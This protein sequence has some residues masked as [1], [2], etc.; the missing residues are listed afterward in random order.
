MG[1]TS[2][3]RSGQLNPT[4]AAQGLEIIERSTNVQAR[5]IE[6]LLDVSRIITGNLSLERRPLELAPV[7]RAAV[8]T[9]SPIAEAKG[10]ALQ[11]HLDD[12]VGLVSGDPL[13]L[14]Q[15]M[16]NLLSNAVKFTRNG[17]C[18]EVRLT[19]RGSYVQITVSDNGQ[20]M[21][22]ETL[23]IIFERFRQADS[24]STRRHGGLGLGLAIVRYLVEAHGGTVTAQSPGEG[25]GATFTVQFPLLTSAQ[26]SPQREPMFS[27][28]QSDTASASTNGVASAEGILQGVRV[29]VVDDEAD[30]RAVVEAILRGDGAV[31]KTAASTLDAWAVLP[32]W[33]PDVLVC[34]IGM[35]DEDGYVLIRRLRALPPDAGAARDIPAVALTAYASDADRAQALAAGFQEHLAKPVEPSALIAVVARLAGRAMVA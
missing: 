5:L 26:E 9:I 23:G 32:A 8:N 28:G 31:V 7:V 1:W 6:D 24:S 12:E 3:L 21:S 30:N 17:G 29:L 33:P 15:V 10:I 27:P 2:L 13:R 35:P 14:E 19:Q 18:V 16:W 4:V 25:Q 20:G 22:E 11:M 34:D